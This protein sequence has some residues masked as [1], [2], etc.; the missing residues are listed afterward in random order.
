M[1]IWKYLMNPAFKK[2][3]FPVEKGQMR[4]TEFQICRRRRRF[5]M[6]DTFKLEI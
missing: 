5:D 2:D 3:V 1:V 4:E 6:T